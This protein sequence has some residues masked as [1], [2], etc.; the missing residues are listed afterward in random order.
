VQTLLIAG[1]AKIKKKFYLAVL[2]DRA[3]GR[4]LVMAS[5]EGGNRAQNDKPR[6]GRLIRRPGL[7]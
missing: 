2:L 3:V 5:T 6:P 4:P 7:E 1:G